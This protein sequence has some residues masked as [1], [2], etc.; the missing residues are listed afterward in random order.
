MGRVEV[1]KDCEACYRDWGHSYCGW[2]GGKGYLE[3]TI[4]ISDDEHFARI[5]AMGHKGVMHDL[6]LE[7][8]FDWVKRNHTAKEPAEADGA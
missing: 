1:K 5:A 3:L 7:F 4:T 8:L 6:D 2:C